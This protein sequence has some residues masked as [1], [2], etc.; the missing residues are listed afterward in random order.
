MKITMPNNIVVQ[1][2][3][4][5]YFLPTNNRS[6]RI[7]ATCAAGTITIAAK[8]ELNIDNQHAAAALAL[9]RK[10]DWPYNLVQGCLADGSYCFVCLPQEKK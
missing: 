5:V 3:R 9:L 6:A 10:L 7:K 8:P 1:A 4:T 2:I